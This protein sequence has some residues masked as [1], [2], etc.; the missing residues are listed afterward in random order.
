VVAELKAS[1]LVL[2]ASQAYRGYCMLIAKTHA[3]EIFQLPHKERADFFDD[4]SRAA[5]AIHNAFKPDKLNYEILGNQTPHLHCHIIPRRN[6]D[7][8]D[9]KYPIWVLAEEIVGELKKLSPPA[10]KSTAAKKPSRKSAKKTSR[11]KKAK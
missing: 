7:P 6:S 3:N 10:R 5:E 11:A 9:R 4:V 8:V 1:W 2:S